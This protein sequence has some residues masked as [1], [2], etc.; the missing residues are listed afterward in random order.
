A[1]DIVGPGGV[2]GPLLGRPLSRDLLATLRGGL[3]DWSR[4]GGAGPQESYGG[5]GSAS[6]GHA[7][8]AQPPLGSLP[9][10]AGEPRHG[11]A[12]A[13]GAGSAGAN[14]SADPFG[15]MSGTIGLRGGRELG[16]DA[17]LNGP[18]GTGIETAS[19]IGM[20]AYAEA[21]GTIGP[22]GLAL[23]AS[24]GSGVYASNT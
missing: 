24:A 6:P 21:G 23:G 1:R 2:T 20:E 7:A 15:N 14:G 4:G 12:V 10:L 9:R 17:R 5:E 8:A 19:Q 16:A 3:G 18:D 22:D 11:R 13:R